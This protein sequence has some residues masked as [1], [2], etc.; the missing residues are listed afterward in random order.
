MPTQ[1]KPNKTDW[2][3]AATHRVTLPSG[4]QATIVIPNLSLL[5]KTG[6]LPNDLVAQALGTIQSGALTAE[7]IAEQSGF[8]AKLV[9]KTVVDPVLTE[10]DVVGD[11]A[12]PFEDIEMLVEFATRQRDLDVL[13]HHLGGLHTSKEWRTFRGL[14][15][16]DEDVASA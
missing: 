1:R 16:L 12:I 2:K 15:D 4:F 6:Y 14:P 8:Y 9:T 11:D 10:E 13:G 5:V 3:K 7:A